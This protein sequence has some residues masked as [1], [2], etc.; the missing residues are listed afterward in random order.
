MV[1]LAGKVTGSFCFSQ[2]CLKIFLDT[3]M[4]NLVPL[5]VTLTGKKTT[6]MKF[7]SKKTYCT[8]SLNVLDITNRETP[9]EKLDYYR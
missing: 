8:S 1:F 9:F 6:K 4:P 2:K 5:P 7:L 3:K